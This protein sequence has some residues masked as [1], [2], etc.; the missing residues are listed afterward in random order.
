MFP[1]PAVV[2]ALRAF[3]AKFPT[4]SPRIYVQSLGAAAELVLDGTCMIGL[5]PL[6][7]SDIALLKHFPLLTV[8]L[9]P[10]VAPDHPLAALEGPI[11]T[12]VLHRHVQLVLTDRSSLTA[13]RDYGDCRA[14]R[15]AWLTSAR[16]SRCFWRGSGGATCPPIWSRMTSRKED[17]KSF[18]PWS[19]IRE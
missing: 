8:D 9:I 11:D 12:H 1:M 10:V 13:G 7:F 19:S 3:T 18:D 17:L 5:L 6:I 2:E 15:G 16:S 4:V 14:A